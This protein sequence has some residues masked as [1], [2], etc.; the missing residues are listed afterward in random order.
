[1]RFGKDEVRV[2]GRNLYRLFET[3]TEQRTR[4]IQEGTDGEEGLKLV[5]AVHVA[6]N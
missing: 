3:I 1:M 5:D 6:R 2:M 4:F